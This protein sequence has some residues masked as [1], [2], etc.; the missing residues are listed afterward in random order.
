MACRLGLRNSFGAGDEFL[1]FAL[2]ICSGAQHLGGEHTI[3]GTLRTQ[4]D[5]CGE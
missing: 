3:G 4:E 2:D 1:K 5:L